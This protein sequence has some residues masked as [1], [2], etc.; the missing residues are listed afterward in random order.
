MNFNKKKIIWLIVV[1][2]IAITIYY[3]F[4]KKKPA[5]VSEKESSFNAGNQSYPL[6]PEESRS[7]YQEGIELPSYFNLEYKISMQ[8]KK[9]VFPMILKKVTNEVI[10]LPNRRS[11]IDKNASYKFIDVMPGDTIKIVSKQRLTYT[12]DSNEITDDF[13]VTDKDYVIAYSQAKHNFRIIG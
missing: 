9:T 5:K 7:E 12:I 6:S 1:V 13:L 8:G 4:F 10:E 11:L 2:L 3:L